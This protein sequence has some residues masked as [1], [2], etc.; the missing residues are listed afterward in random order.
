MAKKLIPENCGKLWPKFTVILSTGRSWTIKYVYD[1]R[2]GEM[3]RNEGGLLMT[4]NTNRE[5]NNNVNMIPR[6]ELIYSHAN[7]LSSF[8]NNL[9]LQV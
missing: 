7:V 5:L 4:A 3:S 6:V 8:I 1:R 9:N 2:G